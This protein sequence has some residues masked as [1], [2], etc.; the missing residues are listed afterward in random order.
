MVTKI[1]ACADIHIKNLEGIM[2]LRQILE[3]FIEDCKNIVKK[4][5]SPENV[6]I[7][8][9]GDLVE[10]KISISNECTLALGWFLRELNKICKTIVVGGNHDA[11]L[12]NLQ[13]VD[14]LTPMFQ[15]G[16]F[17]NV[18]YIDSE[19]GYESG[20]LVDDNITWCLYSMFSEYNRPE[21]IE[22]IKTKNPNNKMV[23]L[24]HGDINGSVNFAGRATDN[25]LDPGM[26]EDLDF[27]IAG[28]IHKRQ[29]IKKNGVKIVYC[30]S[31]KQKNFGETVTGHGYVLWNVEDNTYKFK[32]IKNTQS[33]LYKFEINDIKDIEED[34]EKLLNL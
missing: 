7:V 15:I 9:C 2:D 34:K 29:E 14:S 30:S 12:S 26:F 19:L 8:V 27:V 21:D 25:G 1:I 5:E 22:E 11:I 31:I 4:E 16:D 6:R 10:S 32:D 17:D 33:A 13:R 3:K 24:V 28:H 20:C 18:I 23:G